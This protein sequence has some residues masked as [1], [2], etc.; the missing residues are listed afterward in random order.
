[1]TNSLFDEIV[2]KRPQQAAGSKHQIDF[3]SI[4]LRNVL[5][6]KS[7]TIELD[8]ST[9]LIGNNAVGKTSLLHLITFA[10]FGENSESIRRQQ[11]QKSDPSFVKLVLNCDKQT[12]LFDRTYNPKKDKWDFV[13]LETTGD[14]KRKCLSTLK[15]CEKLFGLTASYWHSTCILHKHWV[16]DRTEFQLQALWK[17]FCG[18]S[19]DSVF[20]D[21]SKERTLIATRI[22]ELKKY[23]NS[24]ETVEDF[25]ERSGLQ[26]AIH[27]LHSSKLDILEYYLDENYAQFDDVMEDP[28]SYLLD[29]NTEHSP[30]QLGRD[31]VDFSF[32]MDGRYSVETLKTLLQVSKN[33][34]DNS[35]IVVGEFDDHNCI[36][37]EKGIAREYE[38]KLIEEAIEDLEKKAKMNEK[39]KLDQ[40]ARDYLT[41]ELEI[42]GFYQLFEDEQS[43][44]TKVFGHTQKLKNLETL[45]NAA[46][47]FGIGT[48]AQ[49]KIWKEELDELKIKYKNVTELVD[50]KTK[51][52]SELTK[53][54]RIQIT[55]V[56]NTLLKNL[57]CKFQIEIG[58]SITVKRSAKHITG[59]MFSSGYE[60]VMIELAIRYAMQSSTEQGCVCRFMFIDELFGGF[61][62]KHVELINKCVSALETQF[63]VVFVV[64][65]HPILIEISDLCQLE[66]QAQ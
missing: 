34:V 36:P 38:I 50:Y 65:H 13:C 7:A 49:K 43:V 22:A 3:V 19:Y 42:D 39:V 29:Q 31:I 35:G 28:N 23:I 62:K 61:D 24:T 8:E 12:F 33:R 26:N 56:A 32:Y 11:A 16:L 6:Y 5:T 10:L 47:H 17:Q 25:G 53:T 54:K 37:I 18:Q 55:K 46:K 40:L 51:F 21:L 41:K 66:I 58:N 45:T 60:R 2:K 48:D 63:K 4:Q 15:T 20:R 27:K 52:Y 44:S 64:T 9:L 1:M 59:G 30:E 57:G 14:K